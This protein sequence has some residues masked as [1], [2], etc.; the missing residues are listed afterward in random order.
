MGRKTR[1][2]D[3]FDNENDSMLLLGTSGGSSYSFSPIVKFRPRTPCQEQYMKLMTIH[4]IVIAYGPPGTG[5]TLLACQAAADNLLSG[6]VSRIVITRPCVSVDENIGFLPGTL[7]EKMAPWMQPVSDVLGKLQVDYDV[8]P[9][10]FMRGQTFND[11]FIIV[12]EA[13]NMTKNQMKMLLTRIG[14]G[15]TMVITG[16]PDQFDNGFE[17][18]GLID[19]LNRLQRVH[20][21]DIG[22]VKFCASDVQR[23]PIIQHIL[24]L[25]TT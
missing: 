19:I 6:K 5:K 2:N 4:P 23:H 10:A 9:L 14:L 7:E 8:I 18:N 1:K 20:V 24:E 16:D 12:D 3:N 13:Q 11:T 15:S 25:Y 22:I 17:F 21:E